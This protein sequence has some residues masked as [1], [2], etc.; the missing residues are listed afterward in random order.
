MQP[1]KIITFVHTQ[2]RLEIRGSRSDF[3]RASHVEFREAGRRNG[4][5]HWN[6]RFIPFIT[7]P[8]T[9]TQQPSSPMA[10]YDYDK[11]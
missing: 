8:N 3:Y 1:V 6:G 7:P 11:D 2:V 10:T 9:C 5:H 4:G